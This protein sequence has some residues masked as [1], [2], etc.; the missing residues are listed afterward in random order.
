MLLKKD[1]VTNKETLKL[2]FQKKT[3]RYYFN[4]KVREKL[5]DWRK[6][7]ATADGGS[8]W[9]NFFELVKVLKF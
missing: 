5:N 3:R 4:N 7:I 9:N 1:S 6:R 2:T 8:L